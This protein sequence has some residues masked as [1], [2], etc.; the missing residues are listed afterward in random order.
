MSTDSFDLEHEVD[1]SIVIGVAQARV[2]WLEKH[3]PTTMEMHAESDWISSAINRLN[4]WRQLME[5]KLMTKPDKDGEQV[6]GDPSVPTPSLTQTLWRLIQL[7][8][9][10][11]EHWFLIPLER[12]LHF[13][14]A[15]ESRNDDFAKW[16]K[17]PYAIRVNSPEEVTFTGWHSYS[18]TPNTHPEIA[19]RPSWMPP[20]AE[21]NELAADLMKC[22][23]DNGDL[24][25]MLHETGMRA[26]RSGEL[27]SAE[28]SV[29]SAKRINSLEQLIAEYLP[30]C[31]DDCGCEGANL[32]CEVLSE[33]DIEVVRN[34]FSRQRW[35]E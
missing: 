14:A 11:P 5:E 2:D 22:R 29:A 23:A 33:E 3:N 1:W 13:R 26:F 28:H 8:D 21:V 6:C 31:A 32:G 27:A 24:A 19:D 4:E 16:R 17:P 18:I 10:Y 7:S 30:V 35:P 20:I 12:E 15:W 25:V 9:T 34:I